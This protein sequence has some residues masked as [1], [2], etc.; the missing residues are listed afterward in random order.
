[1]SSFLARLGWLCAAHPWRVIALWIAILA[2]ALGLA[3][4]IGGQPR[5]DYNAPGAS[6]SIGYDF[7][8]KRFPE[9][10]GADA[11][12]VV[13]TPSG[14]LNTADLDALRD[15][16][17]TVSGVSTVAPPRMS[18]AGDTALIA[19]RYSV[20]V[21][22]F[23]GP[24][25]VNALRRAVAPIQR[26]GLQ[27]ELGGEVPENYTADGGPVERDA[28]LAA[29]CLMLLV[30][31]SIAAAG[32][33]PAVVLFGVG[34][35]LS[36]MR[37]MAGSISISAAA[38]FFATA[39]GIGVGIDYTLLFLAR[40]R[41]NLPLRDSARDAAGAANGSAG[42][43]IVIAGTTV[44]VSLLGLRL[45]GI[46]QFATFGYA[47]AVV[48][49]AFVLTAVTLVPALC[50]LAGHR[51]VRRRAAPA[52]RARTG[53]W[54]HFINKRPALWVL[55][56]LTVLLV[57]GAPVLGMRTWPHDGGSLST[58]DTVRRAHDLIA[59]DFGPG[60][61]GP[62][63]VGVDATALSSQ[64][65]AAT[66]QEL[67]AAAGVANVAEPLYNADRSAA[68]F[69]IEPT[70]APDEKA[71]AE[72]LREVRAQLPNGTYV[73]GVTP[74]FADVA[75][76]LAQRLWLLIIVVVGL[77]AVL[78]TI[79]F[80]A[81]VVAIT[82]ALM[83]LLAVAAT[84]GVLVALFQ[85]GWGAGLFGL[86]GAVPLSSWAAVLLFIILFGLSTDYEVFIVSRVR[87]EWRDT[88]AARD[89]VLRGFVSTAHVVI[90]AAAV[91]VAV[92]VGFALDPDIMVKMLCV[93]VAVGLIIDV[94]VIQMVLLP[95]TM[96]LLGRFA[97]WMPGWRN[98]VGS[99]QGDQNP[100]PAH[101][102]E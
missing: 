97:W 65:V 66:I 5:D 27:V 50:G 92:F 41:E 18:E 32:I 54:V 73:T 47:T 37:I 85:W 79:A 17:R 14:R 61:N 91:M 53:W 49:A 35:G 6:G 34:T 33:A 2:A 15:Q 19:V 57:L 76:R 101:S 78:L 96:A 28:V 12:V 77:A 22:E 93:G 45:A 87:E 30:S 40:F 46:P 21:T 70:T 68:V 67:R 86:P 42:M 95:T 20:P 43:S 7:L 84:Y 72:T 75:D 10:A 1:M 11:R 83:K 39:L 44:L 81:P 24:E 36:L 16:L 56:A 63:T 25:G 31:G 9:M 74:Y 89:S 80:K 55:A 4:A 94:V 59:A 26:S 3:A 38:P 29:G 58:S 82:A 102:G 69:T 23:H 51:L 48:V 60:A 88:G 13:R 8:T 62:F 71:T 64:Q 100:L 90:S 99:G 52:D 98:S